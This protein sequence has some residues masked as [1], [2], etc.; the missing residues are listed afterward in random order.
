MRSH[1]ETE[2]NQMSLNNQGRQ[3]K[4]YVAYRVREHNKK[5]LHPRNKSYERNTKR[6]KNTRIPRLGR[7][8]MAQAEKTRTTST[9]YK[10]R[11]C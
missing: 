10:I 6:I 4:C 3:I 2:K 8:Q 1:S 9:P 5:Q 7:V 11:T